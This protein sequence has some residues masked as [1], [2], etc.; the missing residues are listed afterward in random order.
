MQISVD[1]KIMLYFSYPY[2]II[3]VRKPQIILAEL[4]LAAGKQITL[5]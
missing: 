3:Q 5:F 2:R 4:N 1:I